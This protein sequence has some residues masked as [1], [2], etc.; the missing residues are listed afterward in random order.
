MVEDL[1]LVYRKYWDA[2]NELKKTTPDIIKL[3]SLVWQRILQIVSGNREAEAE[4]KASVDRFHELLPK[5]RF[6]AQ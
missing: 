6:P 3:T 1:S 2:A 5:Y 4:L